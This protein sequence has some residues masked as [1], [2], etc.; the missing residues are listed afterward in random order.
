MPK[1]SDLKTLDLFEIPQ[2][3]T[4]TP[5]SMDY[6]AEVSAMVGIALKETDLDRHEVAMRMSRLLGDGAE[7]SKYMLDA[8][9]S[10][11]RDAYNMPF[12]QAPILELV[13]DSLLFSNW[14]AVKRGGRLLIGKDTL[15]A[16][17]GKLE[18]QKEQAAKKIRDLKKIMGEME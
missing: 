18:R 16:E 7:V 9:S 15:C 6:R 12:Y 1:V 5:A 4:P 11:S 10:E 2:P 17:L 13:T 3:S 8:W 14:L